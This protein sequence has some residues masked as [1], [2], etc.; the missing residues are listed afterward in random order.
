LKSKS[1]YNIKQKDAPVRVQRELAAH[2]GYLSCCRF[3]SDRQ[4]ITA[5]G[6]MSCMLWDIETGTLIERFDDHN[7]DVMRLE[8]FSK[9]FCAK[10]NFFSVDFFLL[11]F[12]FLCSP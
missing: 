4:I 8:F 7:G 12:F 10:N 5:S 2:T 6:D 9:N 11:F 3:L 1:V